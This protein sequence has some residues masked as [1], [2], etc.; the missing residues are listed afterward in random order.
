MHKMHL[1]LNLKPQSKEF[2]DF[3][4][5]LLNWRKGKE[6]IHTGKMKHY[7]PQ[8]GVY[9]Y[10]RYNDKESVM[11]VLNNN[12]NAQTL[13]LSRFKESLNGFT[14]AQDVISG[15][16]LELKSTLTIPAKSPLILELK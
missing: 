12:D 3:T 7:L 9:V 10:F 14:M 5:K 16:P 1:T 2:Y 4:Q 8:N 6:V 11:V 13:D 15:K